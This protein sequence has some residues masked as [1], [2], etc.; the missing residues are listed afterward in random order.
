MSESRVALVTGSAH[1]LGRAIAMELHTAGMDIIVHYRHSSAD[2]S[3]LV[4][5]L[6]SIRPDSALPVAADLT[7]ASEVEK[8]MEQALAFHDRLDALV[9]NASVYRPTSLTEMDAAGFEAAWREMFTLH[10]ETPLTLTRLALPSLRRHR[11][12]VVCITDVFA[13]KS[14]AD[15]PVYCSTKAGLLMLMRCLARDLAPEVRVNAVA[16]GAIL[17]TP[18]EETDPEEKEK[19]LQSLPT[20]RLGKP[21]DIARAVQ[22]LVCQASYVTGAVLAVDGGR[23]LVS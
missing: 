10:M 15:H 5:K 22:Y 13:E 14:L 20:R 2:A 12:S 17:W 23:R 8:L 4:E 1:R 19:I 7:R 21:E 3:E 11:G 6:N 18:G 16:P 9:H